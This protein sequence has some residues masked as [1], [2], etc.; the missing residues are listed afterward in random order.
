MSV[1][2]LPPNFYTS[3]GS[4]ISDAIGACV[5][6]NSSNDAVRGELDTYLETKARNTVTADIQAL[7]DVM[8]SIEH[9]FSAVTSRLT[10]LVRDE[11]DIVS[12]EFA[13]KW[14]KLHNVRRFLS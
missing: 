7:S 2:I 9:D 14:E 5:K 10:I 8:T 3:L 1:E 12:D 13:R 4:Q 11:K 6:D